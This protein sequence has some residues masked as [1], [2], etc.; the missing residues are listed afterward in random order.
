MEKPIPHFIANGKR[1]VYQD[2][3]TRHLD[4]SAYYRNEK[5][6]LHQAQDVRDAKT[7]QIGLA[8]WKRE[9]E[10]LSECGSQPCSPGHARMPGLLR[11]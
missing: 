7:A 8:R 3:I 5:V 2:L 11:L 6:H 4:L 9:V 10:V 1:E